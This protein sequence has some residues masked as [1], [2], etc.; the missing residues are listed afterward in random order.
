MA[1][2]TTTY[3][4]LNLSSPLIVGSCG[5]TSEV[6]KL[7]ELET[8]GA[9]AVVLKS[10]FEEQI[11]INSEQELVDAYNDKFIYSEKSETLDYLDQR[12]SQSH[13]ESYLKL[14]KDAKKELVI[15]VIASVNCITERNWLSFAKD[16]EKA[17]ADAIEINIAIFPANRLKDSNFYDN[18]VHNIVRSIISYIE[19]PLIVKLSPFMTS[20]LYVIDRISKMGANGLVLFNR[21]YNI[22]FD[23]NNLKDTQ[24]IKYSDQHDYFNTLRWISIAS[25]NLDAAFCASTGIHNAETAIKMILAGADAFQIVSAIYKNGSEIITEINNGI[26]NWMEDNGFNSIEQ[27]KGKMSADRLGNPE[28]YQRLQFMKYYSG[29]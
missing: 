19:V 27:F 8:N 6:E 25:E 11:I 13:K 7:K 23:I 14:V 3:A 22:D 4:G 17:G 18:Q 21:F 15:P 5:L 26:L 2:L 28:V 10:L 9:G 29:L 20:P 12:V 24:G 1:E 16:I